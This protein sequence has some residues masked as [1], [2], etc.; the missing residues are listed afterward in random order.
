MLWDFNSLNDV[1]Q[2]ISDCY[3]LYDGEPVLARYV[4]TEDG[5]VHVSRLDSLP[6]LRSDYILWDDGAGWEV[7]LPENGNYNIF[8]S[9]GWCRLTLLPERQWRKALR[10]NSAIEIEWPGNHSTT[11]FLVGKAI[12]YNH[13][14]PSLGD[15]LERFNAGTITSAAISRNVGI[16]SV[17]EAM[18]VSHNGIYVGII[19]NNILELD[20]RMSILYEELSD[21]GFTI[22][23]KELAS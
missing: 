1:N 23:T 7:K 16:H 17:K 2:A 18:V 5:V 15:T 9:H 13:E 6:E 19:R 4:D 10:A 12:L 22:L 14:L 3:V 21:L 20:P 8:G 11:S